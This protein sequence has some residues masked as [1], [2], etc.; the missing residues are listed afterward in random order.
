MT[1]TEA[2]ILGFIQGLTEFLP[3]SSSGH[4]VLVEALLGVHPAGVT[5]EVVVHMGT[6]FA[7]LVYFRSRIVELI[8]SLFD[9]QM[10]KQRAVLGFLLLGTIPAGVIGVA[11]KDFFEAAS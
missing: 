9:S 3:V 6:L 2:I 8:R 4:L 11:F 1:Y 7:V 10:K 5:F